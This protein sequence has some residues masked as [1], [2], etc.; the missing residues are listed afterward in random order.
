MEATI[1][2]S[3]AAKNLAVYAVKDAIIHTFLTMAGMEATVGIAYPHGQKSCA[4]RSVAGVIGWIGNW[5]G[6]GILECTPE[7]ACKLSNLMLGSD[8]VSLSEDALD[9]VAEMTNIIF[10]GMKTELEAHLGAMGLSTPTV[11]YG[12][13]VGMRSSGEAFTVIPIHI[14]EH[15]LHVKLFLARVEEKRTSLS[16]FWAASYSGAL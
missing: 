4:S 5:N 15:L 6:T 8:M 7:F 11:I 2:D 9:A 1:I 16:H 14:A 3:S 12:N 13:D 10:G